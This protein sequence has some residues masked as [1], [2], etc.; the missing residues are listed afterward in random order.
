MDALWV[1]VGAGVVSLGV[2]IWL[3]ERALSRRRQGRKFGA[4]GYVSLLLLLAGVALL[5]GVAAYMPPRTP[6]NSAAETAVLNHPAPVDASAT[7]VY[8]SQG[9]ET[10]S[11]SRA[12]TY[13]YMLIGLAARTGAIRWQRALP[14]CQPALVDCRLPQYAVDGGISYVAVPAAN[15]AM[16]AA[17]RDIDGASLWQTTLPSSQLDVAIAAHDDNVYVLGTARQSPPPQPAQRLQWLRTVF[18]LHATDG[19]QRW[20]SG[21]LINEVVAGTL[22]ATPDAVCLATQVEVQAYRA[23]DGASVWQAHP[24]AGNLYVVPFGGVPPV[25]ADGVMY[26]PTYSSGVSAVR[27]SDG[28]L[29]C[30]AGDGLTMPTTAVAGN[31]LYVSAGLPGPHV[32]QQDGTYTNLETVYA[33]DAA[34]C[35]LRWRYAT[36]SLNSARGL[37]AGDETVYVNADDGIHALRAA[38]GK[39]VWHRDAVNYGA[40]DAGWKF[41]VQPTILGDTLFVTSPL[42]SHTRNIFGAFGT[43]GLMHVFAIAPDGSDYWHTPVGHVTSFR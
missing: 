4:S 29:L 1:G 35:T 38:D 20:S 21:T 6:S 15:G 9:V 8:L 39:V 3:Y 31:T 13:T 41:D 22:L 10:S 5:V 37:V 7:V 2:G 40:R 32:R 16:V 24:D 18:A 34:T 43:D 33:Y 26:L 28:S 42:L 14:N 11:T 27:A 12:S 23:R 25:L 17:Y 19:T 30:K 36:A